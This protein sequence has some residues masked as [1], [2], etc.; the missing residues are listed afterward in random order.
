MKVFI[1]LYVRLGPLGQ[2]LRTSAATLH[3]G[4]KSVLEHCHSKT[5]LM[6]KYNS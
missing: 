2:R 5:L 6:S 3:S 4:T 1:L